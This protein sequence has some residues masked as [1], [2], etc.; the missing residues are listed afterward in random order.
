[1]LDWEMEY[2]RPYTNHRATVLPGAPFSFFF[3]LP[4]SAR[5]SLSTL[6][7]RFLSLALVIPSVLLRLY[8]PATYYLSHLSHT[9]LSMYLSISIY[10][11]Y[12]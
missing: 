5:F 4:L 8:T 11:A 2:E 1:M 6:S 12:T 10:F 7:G 3:L 9:S